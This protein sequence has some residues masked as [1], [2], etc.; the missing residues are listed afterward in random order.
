MKK[1]I[2]IRFEGVIV[3]DFNPEDAFTREIRKEM[4]QIE[5]AIFNRFH[6]VILVH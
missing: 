6:W 1:L 5:S 2:V 3:N 4:K